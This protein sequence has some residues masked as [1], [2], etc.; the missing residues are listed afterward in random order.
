MKRNLELATPKPELAARP[1]LQLLSCPER[2]GLEDLAAELRSRELLSAML[3]FAL[4]VILILT[5]PSSWS[6][7]SRQRN[8]RRAVGDLLLRR[9]AGAQPLNGN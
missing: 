4:L 8:F 5:S 2:R 6:A 7:G 3:V 9:H 1:S